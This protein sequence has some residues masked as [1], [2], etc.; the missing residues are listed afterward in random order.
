MKGLADKNIYSSGP[1]DSNNSVGPAYSGVCVIYLLSLGRLKIVPVIICYS[2]TFSFA[3]GMDPT[4]MVHAKGGVAVVLWTRMLYQC[5]RLSQQPGI[6][7]QT[8][9]KM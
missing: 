7:K 3:Q 5:M 9:T 4:K 1:I 8:E 2:M 6:K